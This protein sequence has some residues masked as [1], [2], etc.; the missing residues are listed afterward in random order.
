VIILKNN[1][2]LGERLRELRQHRAMSQEQLA[3]TSNITPAYLG[4]V[5]RG[6]KNITVHTLEKVCHALNISL[7]EFFDTAIVQSN[8]KD[9]IS[10]Q[11]LHQLHNKTTT[12][13][14]AVLKIVKLVFA[15]KE[16]RGT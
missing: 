2:S 1:F 3:H 16:M 7:S 9:E 13:K 11:I 6:T 8:A 10:D 5:E 14:Q 15:V 12:E 4:Q